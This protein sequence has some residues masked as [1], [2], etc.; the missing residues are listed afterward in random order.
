LVRNVRGYTKSG[1]VSPTSCVHPGTTQRFYYCS[2]C[3][4]IRCV[5]IFLVRN[6]FRVQGLSV[7]LSLCLPPLRACTLPTNA[8][9]HAKVL[10]LLVLCRNV[11]LYTKSGAVSPT[12]CVH[13]DA[14]FWVQG[15]GFRV[16]LS[17]PTWCVHPGAA[18]RVEG[19]S[20]RWK[21][22][23][24]ATTRRWRPK[25]TRRLSHVYQPVDGFRPLCTRNNRKTERFG[26]RLVTRGRRASPACFE[27]GSPY[28][29]KCLGCRVNGL[30]FGDPT[31][32]RAWVL[33]DTLDLII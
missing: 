5:L 7:F 9:H 21:E 12:S 32:F 24:H 6:V 23:C 2:H 8:S 28:V 30:G 3:V 16:P 31:P 13:P 1:A 15:S 33:P 20:W 22:A 25:S 29:F 17:P 18:L 19:L 27:T 26:C 14:P 11:S 10:L 4:V